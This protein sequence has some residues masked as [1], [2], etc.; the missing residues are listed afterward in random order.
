MGVVSIWTQAVTPELTHFNIVLYCL[1][2]K[3]YLI[4]LILS[5]YINDNSIA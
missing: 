1:G 5:F 3:V 4:L 2:E